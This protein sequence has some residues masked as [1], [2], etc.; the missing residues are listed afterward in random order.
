M[1]NGHLSAILSL[2][3]MAPFHRQQQRSALPSRYS[4]SLISPHKTT[5]RG[6][7][8]DTPPSTPPP[9]SSQTFSPSPVR[10]LAKLSRPPTPNLYSHIS[11]L[12][13][14]QSD[15]AVLLSSR[16]PP[17]SPPATHTPFPPP[18]SPQTKTH[19]PKKNQ[20]PR[21]SIQPTP[22]PPLSPPSRRK[23]TSPSPPP[24]LILPTPPTT[25]PPLLSPPPPTPPPTNSPPFTP[26]PDQECEAGLTLP[27]KRSGYSEGT[28]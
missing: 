21:R 15:Q 25:P 19:P 2:F 6:G 11:S 24:P 16:A 27:R 28:F 5:P 8:P 13:P 4:L 14:I 1:P 18:P 20:H 3:R 22:L 26:P 10:R 7:P 23:R 12:A 17:A 9:S